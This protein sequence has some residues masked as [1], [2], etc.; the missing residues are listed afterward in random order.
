MRKW[1]RIELLDLGNGEDEGKALSRVVVGL[2]TVSCD[3][4]VWSYVHGS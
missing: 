1:L 4:G 3:I 2:W